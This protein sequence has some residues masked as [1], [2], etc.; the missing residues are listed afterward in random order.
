MSDKG[1][2]A[3]LTRKRDL[4]SKDISVL[5]YSAYSDLSTSKIEVFDCKLTKV[6]TIYICSA[7]TSI[8]LV[9]IDLSLSF[10]RRSRFRVKIAQVTWVWHFLLRTFCPKID[11]QV[12]CAILTRKRD[13]R[14]KDTSVLLDSAHSDLSIQAK[15]KC[16]TVN[17]PKLQPCLFEILKISTFSKYKWL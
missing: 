5:L 9:W 11:S 4:R 6:T 17:W 8:L 15:L 16:F 10:D 7:N 12:T 2:C 3:I 1:T 14:S 13:L